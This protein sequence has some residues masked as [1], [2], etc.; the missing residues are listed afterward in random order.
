MNKEKFKKYAQ[1]KLDAASLK[2]QIEALAPEILEMIKS[3][4]VDKVKLSNVG[5]FVVETRKTYVYSNKVKEVE[6][7]CNKLKE[8]EKATG[9]AKAIESYTLKFFAKKD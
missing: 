8:E 3:G 6:R 2:A 7:S 4:G 9:I 1:L 5:I